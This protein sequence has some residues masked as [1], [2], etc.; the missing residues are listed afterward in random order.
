MSTKKPKTPAHPRSKKASLDEKARHTQ[1][2]ADYQA[3]NLEATREKAKLRMRRRRAQIKESEESSKE[4]AEQRREADAEYRQMKRMRTYVDRHG[5]L[6]L[7]NHYIPLKQQAGAK[8]IPG[9][10]AEGKKWAKTKEARAVK[11][12]YKR[13]IKAAGPF[14]K[15][16]MFFPSN[17]FKSMEDHD[18][19]SSKS[20][21]LVPDVGLFTSKTAANSQCGPDNEG[22]WKQ[23]A[24]RRHAEEEWASICAR[25]HHDNRGGVPVSRALT[26]APAP[27]RHHHRN[28]TQLTPACSTSARHLVKS[29]EPPP[30]PPVKIEEA[31]FVVKQED[32]KPKFKKLESTDPPLD[33]PSRHSARVP[34]VRKT[35]QRRLDPNEM[36]FYFLSD[37]PNTSLDTEASLDASPTRSSTEAAA[38]VFAAAFSP[39]PTDT[40]SRPPLDNCAQAQGPHP[41]CPTCGNTYLY[42]PASPR[43]PALMS[44]RAP[45]TVGATAPA[46]ALAHAPAP[47]LARASTASPVR[48]AARELNSQ[49]GVHLAPPAF[50]GYT[51]RVLREVL[52]TYPKLTCFTST[53]LRRPQGVFRQGFSPI[54]RVRP[55]VAA[56]WRRPQQRENLIFLASAHTAPRRSLATAPLLSGTLR[57]IESLDPPLALFLFYGAAA[58]LFLLRN[59]AAPA[60]LARAPAPGCPAPLCR[61]FATTPALRLVPAPSPR[62]RAS[63]RPRALRLATTPRFARARVLPPRLTSL[64]RTHPV[65]SAPPRPPSAHAPACRRFARH[66]APAFRL[67]ASPCPRAAHAPHLAPARASLPHPRSGPVHARPLSVLPSRLPSPSHLA[68]RTSPAPHVLAPR[69]ALAPGPSCTVSPPAHLLAPPR[70]ASRHRALLCARAPPLHHRAPLRAPPSRHRAPFRAPPRPRPS[71][72]RPTLAPPRTA[73]LSRLA[74]LSHPRAQAPRTPHPASCLAPAHRASHPR[75][76]LP[77]RLASH[78]RAPRCA[79]TPRFTLAPP[80]SRSRTPL[81]FTTSP[82]SRSLCPRFALALPPLCP[83]FAPARAHARLTSLPQR[84]RLRQRR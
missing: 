5:L 20:Y 16:E 44:A 39:R 76:A 81:R 17:N 75:P 66:P 40:P 13:R 36:D 64:Q 60:A 25:R 50:S 11:A 2:Q 49:A 9:I 65:F 35:P 74:S 3:R 68:L 67:C 24:Q 38:R 8:Y 73:S 84:T 19:H 21:W 52:G 15:S 14:E 12:D 7:T 33:P 34:E 46:P 47:A 62:P 32:H 79:P 22:R 26:T 27:R 69:F 57:N 28:G 61:T 43:P 54:N 23:H 10:L 83:R 72:P 31:P 29:E 63:F 1:A 48:M 6:A 30:T 53:A 4:A 41:C 37:S 51:R 82:R 78:P 56:I 70:T 18:T 45:M 55:L 42:A 59:L 71:P 77:Q 80:P 58:P